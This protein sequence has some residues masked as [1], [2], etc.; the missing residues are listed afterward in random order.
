MASF[1]YGKVGVRV[2][3]L[4]NK[5]ANEL[6]R[7]LKRVEKANQHNVQVAADLGRFNA[8]MKRAL[9]AQSGK[10]VHIDVAVDSAKMR[11]ALERASKAMSG[12]SVKI[13]VSADDEALEKDL[14]RIM[15]RLKNHQGG[16]NI[17]VDVKARKD[18]Y[19]KIENLVSY[20]ER[21]TKPVEVPIT[22][23]TNQERV[24]SMVARAEKA[25]RSVSVNIPV[26]VDAESL[27]KDMNATMARIKNMGGA[28]L[29]V[30]L[31]DRENF[32]AEFDR[33][34]R[35]IENTDAALTV[36]A[37][38]DDAGAK[39]QLSALTR[40][41]WV[42]VFV[43]VNQAAVA[44]VAS[45]MSL[46]SGFRTV[47]GLSRILLNFA[48][49]IDL[50]L[51]KLALLASALSLVG[52]A[53]LAMTSNIFGFGLEL[54]RMVKAG[55]ALPGMLA[56][57]TV[58]AASL[59]LALKDIKTV[60]GDLGPRFTALQ[61]AM[62]AKFW[63]QAEQPI[64]RMVD[65]LFPELESG[66]TRVSNAL[67]R[68]FG[69]IADTLASALG[70]GQ[71][72]RM[73]DYLAESIDIATGGM[74]DFVR[75]LLNIGE[76]G[77]RYLPRL[78][79][80]FTELARSFNE[81]SQTADASA[82]VE[83]GLQMV[84]A[85]GVALHGLGRMWAAV[86]QAALDSG[87]G[88]LVGFAEWTQRAADKLN[89]LHVQD[90]LRTYFSAGHESMRILGQALEALG[91][92]LL[93]FDETFA[94][95]AEQ[96][97]R[98]LTGLSIMLLTVFQDPYLLAAIRGMFDAFVAGVGTVSQSAPALVQIFQVV[99]DAIAR[100]T[101]V[102][103]EVF[104]AGVALLAPVF[105]EV[106]AAAMA[107]APVLG[108]WLVQ[109][110]VWL[111]DNV[112]PLVTAISQ[113]IVAN[114]E[115]AATILLV[116]GAVGGLIALLAPMVVSL[117][118]FVSTVAQGVAAAGGFSAVLGAITGAF[119]ALS[120]P[121][122]VAVAAVAGLVALF[123]YAWTTSEQFRNA[124]T[125]LVDAF[126]NFIAPIVDAVVP[127]LQ[128]LGQIFWDVA[129][130]V[131]DAATQIMSKAL[132][133]AAAILTALQPVVDFL[134][135]VLGAA[136]T[137]LV[138]VVSAAWEGIKS[139]VQTATQIIVGIFDIFIG[140]ITGNWSQFWSGIG[141]VA[142]GA[143][144][145]LKS[146]IQ[147]AFNVIKSVIDGAI[148]IITTV[149]TSGMNFL[150]SMASLTMSR[151]TSFF[152]SG[153][154][155][156]KNVVRAG[157]DNVVTFFRELPGRARDAL[158]NL[159]SYLVQ[160]GKALIGGF[161]D[162]IKSMAGQAAEA[163]RGVVQSVRDFFP[164]SPAKRGPFS[165][166]GYTTHSG[167]ALIQDFG[168]AIASSSSSVALDVERAVGRVQ[169]QFNLTASVGGDSGG[170]SAGV[171]V[172]NLTV[173]TPTAYDSMSADHYARRAAEVL[174]YNIG[175]VVV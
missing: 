141:Q 167:K 165:G 12:R 172:E 4:T 128:T 61:D 3:P 23:D 73:F 37:D 168:K 28:T 146:I 130:T 51:P 104:N 57:F 77:G 144:L 114:P 48:T 18:F 112:L 38:L 33:L 137:A 143:M 79:Q 75:G 86:G 126:L 47:S 107:L 164:F 88:G 76:I 97:A 91:G 123:A 11:A 72:T 122:G 71:L 145:L 102:L 138:G 94:H 54:G 135:A 41:R 124:V 22:F 85:F 46:L 63:A 132:E 105:A 129:T 7:D 89:E 25:F 100:L 170:S 151:I 2:Y 32:L 82:A 87:A 99:A 21:K 133:L 136:F 1:V 153:M 125:G 147:T 109:S 66:L 65:T 81:W 26:G 152:T 160:S 159:G 30:S 90:A 108:E 20:V 156:A 49:N 131:L 9:A 16:V 31:G 101:P 35:H 98:V 93:N 80:W 70:S 174:A 148:S 157:V 19:Q 50:V 120:G 34:V 116:V 139:A 83:Q 161:I 15:V 111:K 115:L 56:G 117:V 69:Q 58:G 42:E 155:S 40:P 74:D 163:A 118:G 173:N 6:K 53:A 59:F 166:R 67:G 10:S 13:P 142:D 103:A 119:T 78:A 24:K 113:W 36:D 17:P 134:G 68:Q 149:F 110:L 27:R 84:Q 121:V 158:G 52:G 150:G 162:G 106:M 62:S 39:A 64:R 8:S 140:L 44:R 55:L 175:K 169:S 43:R 95:M 5:F 60:L 45:A 171:V 154:E 29:P 14:Q 92:F 127:G 96:G